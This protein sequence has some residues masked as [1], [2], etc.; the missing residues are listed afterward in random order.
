[1]FQ[2][3]RGKVDLYETVLQIQ[4]ETLERY[5]ARS[6]VP[7]DLEGGAGRLRVALYSH[8]LD[9]NKKP[10][11]PNVTKRYV[12]EQRSSR[13]SCPLWNLDG[14]YLSKNSISM[15]EE[16]AAQRV[17]VVGA[18]VS[19][20]RTAGLLASEG[21]EVTIFEARSRI[22]GRV[23]QSN[24]LGCPLDVGAS[25]IHGTEGNPFVELA[26]KSMT[27]T[28]ACGAV[29]SMFD[30]EGR[31]MEHALAKELYEKVWAIIDDASEYSKTQYH[32]I[33][34]G[35]S[36]KSFVNSKLKGHCPDEP[37]LA[38]IIEMWGAFMGA[39]Y[40]TQSLKNL[41][42]DESIEGGEDDSSVSPVRRKD[43]VTN[44]YPRQFV[45]CIDISEDSKEYG[46]GCCGIG[47]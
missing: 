40:E 47:R 4:W 27:T 14:S 26:K 5:S 23:H 28:V 42:L 44:S 46:R 13:F 2:N 31:Y 18:G 45:R 35:T 21:F 38:S 39:D 10:P 12:W 22:G 32:E 16:A 9:T 41:C 15:V 8:I 6:V 7:T 43:A 36:L 34:S 19:G 30:M 11:E 3:N 25:W 1:M 20:L 33:P 17:C 37:L 24:Q 29:C